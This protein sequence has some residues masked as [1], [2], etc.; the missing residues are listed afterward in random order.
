VKRGKRLGN[1]LLAVPK[2]RQVFWRSSFNHP[3]LRV[4]FFLLFVLSA[5]GG[6]LSLLD[7][8]LH[9]IM[10]LF[11]P[12]CFFPWSGYPGLEVKK[13]VGWASFGLFFFLGYIHCNRARISFPFMFE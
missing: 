7:W 2:S 3:L 5:F 9:C 13:V 11:F 12:L 4:F 6:E 1:I 8:F 10:V